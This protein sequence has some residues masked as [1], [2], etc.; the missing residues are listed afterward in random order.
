LLGFPFLVL[1]LYIIGYLSF[2]IA[3]F[4]HIIVS[5]PPITPIGKISSI[6]SKE[7]LNKTN[8]IKTIVYSPSGVDL[9]DRVIK[10]VLIDNDLC[11]NDSKS[12]PT[13]DKLWM[14]FLV[15]PGMYSVG[16]SFGFGPS[17]EDINYKIYYNGSRTRHLYGVDSLKTNTLELQKSIDNAICVKFILLTFSKSFDK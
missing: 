15:N 13:E 9:V 6:Y 16:I 12:F 14:G 3:N 4:N 17:K 7:N 10:Q 11:L 2:I 8:E 1:F 5:H